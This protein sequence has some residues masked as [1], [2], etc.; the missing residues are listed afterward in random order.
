MVSA[1]YREKYY[2]LLLAQSD[3]SVEINASE[4]V[5]K[6]ITDRIKRAWRSFGE[7]EPY[8]SV[9]SSDQFKVPNFEENREEFYRSGVADV[10]V[11]LAFFRRSKATFPTDGSCLEVGC[12]VGRVTAALAPRLRSIQAYV[13]S[14]RSEERRVGTAGVG[15]C[16]Y[17]GL[18]VL[19]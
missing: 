18:A 9:L 15:S 19:I 14:R 3:M 10:E 17:G 13:I 5:L 4:G 16:R 7:D 8:W 2:R 12:G 1:P 11:M 6:S